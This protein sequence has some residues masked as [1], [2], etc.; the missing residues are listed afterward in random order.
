M[1]TDEGTSGDGTDGDPDGGGYH[2]EVY[3]SDS[4]FEWFWWIV[5]WLTVPLFVAYLVY[6]LVT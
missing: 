3:G 4:R 1:R 5:T 2:G 6:R